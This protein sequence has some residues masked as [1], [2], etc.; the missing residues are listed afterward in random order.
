[1]EN[2]IK[3]DKI[4]ER[5]ITFQAAEHPDFNEIGMG[6]SVFFSSVT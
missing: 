3:Q 1:M 4:P 5:V 6:S 2:V